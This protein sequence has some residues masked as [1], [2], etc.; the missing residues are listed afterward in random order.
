ASSAKAITKCMATAT[1]GIAATSLFGSFR[2]TV[3]SLTHQAFAVAVDRPLI[4]VGLLI[5]GSVPFMFSSLTIRAVERAASR[6]VM[7]V[8]RQF[9]EHPGIM[10]GMEKPE[11][12]L[13]VDIVTRDSLRELATPGLIAVLTPIA[14]GF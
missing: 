11:Y 2:D 13:V 6:V 10:A 4:L 5:G 8:R 14:V 1:A 3:T 7:E 12:G 9:R